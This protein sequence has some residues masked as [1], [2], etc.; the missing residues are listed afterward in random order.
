MVRNCKTKK[1]TSEN[2]LLNQIKLETKGIWMQQT[3]DGLLRT[4]IAAT[5]TTN[6][7]G[8]QTFLSHPTS[9]SKYNYDNAF[10]PVSL[11]GAHI[12]ISQPILL[13][14]HSGLFLVYFRFF[15][16]ICSLKFK[17]SEIWTG[18]ISEEGLPADLMTTTT[19]ISNYF[20]HN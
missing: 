18:I 5:T 19:D 13:N 14:V 12:R 17:T 15:Q 7:N 2:V 9:K 16:T 3:R 6:K 8:C 4:T 1:P 11:K 20:W 10:E